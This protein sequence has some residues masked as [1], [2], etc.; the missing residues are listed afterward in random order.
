MME[1]IDLAPLLRESVATPYSDLV[2]RP[3]GAAVRGRIEQ[4]MANSVHPTMQLDF[5]AIGLLDFSC[6]DEVV[7]KLLLNECGGHPC[8]V[9]LLGVKESHRETLDHVLERQKPVA[10]RQG[11]PAPHALV[12]VASEDDR[13]AVATR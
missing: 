7:A 9:V 5:S 12:A 3:T 8:C 11:H 6:A 13:Q 10:Q 1:R 4:R 2:T